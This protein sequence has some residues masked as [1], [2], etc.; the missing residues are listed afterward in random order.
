MIVL[1]NES[2]PISLPA[3]GFLPASSLLFAVMRMGQKGVTG[4]FERSSVVVPQPDESSQRSA[5]DE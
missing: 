2:R 5:S 3:L 4:T 1:V